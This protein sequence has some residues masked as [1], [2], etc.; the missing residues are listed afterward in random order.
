MAD[1]VKLL[2]LTAGGALKAIACDA[3]EI[4]VRQQ[5]WRLPVVIIV[6]KFF[7]AFV[8]PFLTQ[9]QLGKRF[10]LQLPSDLSGIETAAV[11]TGAAAVACAPEPLRAFQRPR[12][13]LHAAVQHFAVRNVRYRIAMAGAR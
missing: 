7:L 1:L 12:G 9:Q 13:L 4:A 10:T 6:N 2:G 11:Q 3:R 5:V 8:F